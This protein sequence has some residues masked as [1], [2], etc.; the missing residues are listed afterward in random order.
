MSAETVFER[1]EHRRAVMDRLIREKQIDRYGLFAVTTEGKKLPDGSESASGFV[2]T[3]DGQ[4][5]RWWLDWDE[6]KGLPKLSRWTRVDPEADW[7]ED[8]EYT[9]AVEAA[10][11]H[12]S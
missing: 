10:G 2:I 12:S 11:I 4:C 1:R 3:N 7:K 9:A 6:E 5:Y 8:E